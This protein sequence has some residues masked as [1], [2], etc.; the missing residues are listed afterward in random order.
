[1]VGWPRDSA[2]ILVSPQNPAPCGG[3]ESNAPHAGLG[4]GDLASEW[5]ADPPRADGEV[6]T[7]MMYQLLTTVSSN[8]VTAKQK[9]DRSVLIRPAFAKWGQWPLSTYPGYQALVCQPGL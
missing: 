2:H 7:M 6:L 3:Q 8:K 5:W 4:E 9:G 1:M